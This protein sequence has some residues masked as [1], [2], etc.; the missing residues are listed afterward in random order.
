MLWNEGDQGQVALHCPGTMH[1]A[2]HQNSSTSG[3]R[4]GQ[5][6]ELPERTLDWPELFPQGNDR[7]WRLCTCAHG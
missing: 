6:P 5:N 3:R 1:P 2:H 7:S 4:G